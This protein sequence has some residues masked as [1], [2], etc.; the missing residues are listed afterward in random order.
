MSIGPGPLV[1]AP[2]LTSG[3]PSDPATRAGRALALQLLGVAL[4]RADGLAA[5]RIVVGAY[6]GWLADEH[7]AT[8][9]ILA[10]V[11]L[12]RRLFPDHILRFDEPSGSYSE[13][14]R[15]TAW[16]T[17]VAAC[18]MRSGPT[19]LV[20]RSPQQDRARAAIEGRT[21]ATVAGEVAAVSPPGPLAG[22]AK[23]HT[24]AA[25]AAAA[26]TLDRLADLGWRAVVGEGGPTRRA[27]G[28]DAVAER[29]ETFDPLAA[30][31]RRTG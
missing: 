23:A 19:A 3:V 12:R 26:A 17:L 13:S 28:G 25:I 7:A 11:T 20:M 15:A 10:E 30:L 16:P 22:A 2:D 1:V 14:G 5:E 4:A 29:T 8:A 21:I 18:L 27:I 24:Q 6:P 9:R 31:E